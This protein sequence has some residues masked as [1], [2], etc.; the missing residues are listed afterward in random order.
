MAGL[1]RGQK[2]E[3]A[4]ELYLKTD[5]TQ[6]AICALVGCSTRSLTKWIKE[7]KWES[8]KISFTI[9]K[10]QELRRIYIQIREINNGIADREEGKRF[11][12]TK[13]A[14]ILSKLAATAKNLESDTSVSEVID[15]FISFSKFL[16]KQD[17]NKAKEVMELQDAYIKFRLSYS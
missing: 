11:A 1:S 7:G 12:T 16:Q 17:F 5:S 15:V 14:D 3:L 6:K 4:K 10:E 9:S 13:E 2:Q 8:L